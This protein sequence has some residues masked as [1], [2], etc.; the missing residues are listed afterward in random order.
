MFNTLMSPIVFSHPQHNLYIVTD[1]HLDLVDAPYQEFVSMLSQLEQPQ[2]VICLGD[3]FKVWLAP[4]QFWLPINQAVMQAFARLQEQ[5]VVIIFV[6][7]NREVI[8]PRQGNAHGKKQF[9]FTH[10]IHDHG[11]VEWGDQRYG[12]IHGDTINRQDLTYLR[13]RKIA[14]S[15]GF[16]WFF[17]AM[18]IPLARQVARWLENTL[19]QSNQEFKIAFPNQ[20]VETFAQSVLEEVD[21]Y[22]VGHFHQDREFQFPHLRGKLRIVP[23]WLSRRAILKID[24]KGEIQTLYFRND[25]FAKENHG[26]KEKT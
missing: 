24:T 2:A 9:P 13:W 7:G 26:H 1:S 23:D 5:G 18:P 15:R 17:R 20:D 22:F 8:L 10:L 21:W 12:L 3:L 14:R 19:A 4:P 6:I 25:V 11:Y 16:E